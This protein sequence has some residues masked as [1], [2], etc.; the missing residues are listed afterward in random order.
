MAAV[1]N[2]GIDGAGQTALGY[3]GPAVIEARHAVAVAG[4]QRRAVVEQGKADL[5]AAAMRRER[6]GAVVFRK[7]AERQRV[8]VDLGRSDG[9]WRLAG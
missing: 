8:T 6:E 9:Q 5:E 7:P 1:G 4:F 2:V 3:L